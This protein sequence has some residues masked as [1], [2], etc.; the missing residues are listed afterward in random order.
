MSTA[1]IATDTFYPAMERFPR[2]ATFLFNDNQTAHGDY[3]TSLHIL[4]ADPIVFPE[5]PTVTIAPEG[6][7]LHGFAIGQKV[8]DP[9]QTHG[10]ELADTYR[11]RSVQHIANMALL[12]WSPQLRKHLRLRRWSNTATAYVEDGDRALDAEATMATLAAGGAFFESA[13]SQDV[14]AERLRSVSKSILASIVPTLCAP[15]E[16]HSAIAPMQIGN[17]LRAGG[18]AMRFLHGRL[19]HEP[20]SDSSKTALVHADL[21]RGRV[22]VATND[23]SVRFHRVYSRSPR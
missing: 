15:T 21:D 11:F 13:T 16:R 7:R 17:A 23:T 14:H 8:G 2:R 1:A 9:V 22:T 5:G 19:Q 12:G 10:L 3:I 18:L 4:N 6:G 20:G